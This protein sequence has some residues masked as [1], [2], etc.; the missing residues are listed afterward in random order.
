[1]LSLC[2]LAILGTAEYKGFDESAAVLWMIMLSIQLLPY[3]ATVMMAVISARSYRAEE[4]VAS[5]STT[6]STQPELP[7]SRLTPPPFTGEVPERSEGG[8]VSRK[9]SHFPPP[10]RCARRLPRHAG[11][12]LDRYHFPRVQYPVRVQ[13]PFQRAHHIHL[14]RAFVAYDLLAFQHADA[15]LCAD[16]AA[17]TV[18]DV[19]HRVAISSPRARKATP[20]PP[21]GTLKLKWILPSPRCPN[22]TARAPAH[23][24]RHRRHAHLQEGRNIGH[25]HGHIVLE[26]T[27]PRASAPRRRSRAVPRTPRA[28]PRSAPAPHRAGPQARL[29]RRRSG[30]PEPPEISHRTYH[31]LFAASGSRAP[32][33]CRSTR[34]SAM[35]GISSN[36][37]TSPPV[38]ACIRA[39]RA[40]AAPGD[41]TAA[42]AVTRTRGR[43]NSFSAAAVITRACLPIR[44]TAISDHSLYCPCARCA[45]DPARAHPPAPPRAPSTRSRA[46]P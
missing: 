19:V 9:N 4:A 14:H 18:H 45:G 43:A 21:S 33:M 22:D 11:E 46:E 23:D 17:E 7:E 27:R 41:S 31:G 35:R 8:G 2:S 24:L 39:S 26:R 12:E 6:T 36:D 25:R 15:M 37:D 10:S 1:M 34:S 40:T 3:A 5:V 32:G 42:K 13:R 20:S 16:R 44:G 38:A 30:S 29:A 28:V